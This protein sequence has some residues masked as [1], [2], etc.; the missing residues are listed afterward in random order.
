VVCIELKFCTVFCRKEMF[1][2]GC[3]RSKSQVHTSVEKLY[4]ICG[5]FLSVYQMSI[6]GIGEAIKQ[7][8]VW[9]VSSLLELNQLQWPWPVL[10]GRGCGCRCPTR[11][12]VSDSL[13]FLGTRQITLGIRHGCRNPTRVS[14]SDTGAGYPTRQKN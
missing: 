5:N 3:S 8:L 14:E 12:Q 4:Q 6:H 1:F 2:T 10:H 13:E 9:M 11:V 7:L